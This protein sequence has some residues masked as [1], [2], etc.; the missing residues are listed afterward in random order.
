VRS[1][2]IWYDRADF[3]PLCSMM[4]MNRIHRASG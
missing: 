1:P 4:A 3:F 2:R